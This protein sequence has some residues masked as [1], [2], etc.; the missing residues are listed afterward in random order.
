[1]IEEIVNIVFSNKAFNVLS[2]LATTGATFFAWRTT[3][4]NKK[5][6]KEQ[7]DE[8]HRVERPRIIPLNRDIFL[9]NNRPSPSW[10]IENGESLPSN[11]YRVN[12]L[13]DFTFM[14]INT[15]KS[16]AVKIDLTF[17]LVNVINAVKKFDTE[18]DDYKYALTID[19]SEPR[20]QNLGIFSFKVFH[21][22]KTYG[23]DYTSNYTI[24]PFVQRISLLKSNDSYAVQLPNYFVE[25]SNIQMFIL[26]KTMPEVKL[27][28]QYTDQ[29]HTQHTDIYTMK[30]KDKPIA[31]S[32]K[33]EYFLDFD[34]V[35]TK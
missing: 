11:S 28:I 27:T 33:K 3:I 21:Q 35:S 32:D 23:S 19:Q 9:T 20:G 17:E 12:E 14:L 26:N 29:Y 24:D 8:Q 4:A 13:N 10:T 6:N 34:N 22:E 1:M 18:T 31:F 15:G 30:V 16:F 2:A 5:Q 25:L 7:F